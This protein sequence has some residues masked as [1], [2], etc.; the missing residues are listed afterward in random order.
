MSFTKRFL[1]LPGA[2]LCTA[3]ALMGQSIP[4]NFL[5]LDGN[6]TVDG[7]TCTA[8]NTPAGCKDDWNLL[9]GTGGSNPTGSA[10]GS[11]VRSFISGA[12]SVAVFTTG[13]SKDPLDVTSWKWK[14]GG[15]P[16]KDAITNA[17]AAAYIAPNNHLILAFGADRFAVNGDANIGLWF[18]QQ[19]VHPV[20][21]TG[22]GFSGAH[23]L[24]DIFIVSSFTQGGGVSTI[25]VYA[26]DP[27]CGSG[28]K[29][30]QPG[31]CA[32][33]NL[34]LKF[35]STPSSTCAG[36]VEGCAIVNPAAINVSWPYLAK[37]GSN[38]TQIPEGG[39]YEG[40]LDVT[41]LV[42]GAA[43][44]FNSFLMETRSAQTPSAVL[45]DFV[46]GSFVVCG[47]TTTK[48]CA[49][50]GTVNQGGASIHYKFNGTVKNTGFGTLYN[51]T[52]VDTLPS[53]TSNVV[54][55]P[56][57]GVISSI[58]GGATA[59]W[60]VEFDS[61]ALTV[62]NSALAK[63]TINSGSTPG[64]CGDSGTVCSSSASDS[65]ST[66]P[67]NTITISKNC[68]VPAT[69]PNAT[70][71]GTQLV[72][73][74]GL[75]AVR[76]NFSGIIS[77]TGQTALS[78]ITLTDNPGA[79]SPGITVFWP[80]SSK[81]GVIPPGGSAKY[82]GYYLPSGT[83]ITPGDL[84]GASGRYAFSDEIKITGA[85]AGLGS[86]PGADATCVST[87]STGAQA[88]AGATCNICPAGATCGGN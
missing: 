48:T 87:F 37:F 69:F 35:S 55:T 62:Q 79:G 57:N 29:N 43:T 81:P 33:S 47:L 36:V 21:S 64:A 18:F 76:V 9:N 84:G 50:D 28:V 88:C 86:N 82:S 60:S 65:C 20:G 4:D 6:S 42:G 53:G 16:D 14:N 63:G 2:V 68:G 77:N 52:I 58:L 85:T 41:A 51:V 61:T 45:K 32:E 74:G 59:N 23:T 31:D 44:C 3:A 70:L 67:T 73:S 80:D 26:W 83:S 66:N 30:P 13:G 78:G 27:G 71:P 24:N 17:Y 34:R 19:D 38:S 40:G 56:T 54:Y 25:T 8:P 49:G 11:L 7:T 12:A 10:G 75:A 1:L 72:S 5:E 46:S 15:T 39:L 22:G